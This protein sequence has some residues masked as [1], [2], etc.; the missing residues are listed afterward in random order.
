[1]AQWKGI[2]GTD[3]DTDTVTVMVGALRTAVQSYVQNSGYHVYNANA[4][5][6]SRSLFNSIHVRNCPRCVP[7]LE[8]IFTIHV[9][10]IVWLLGLLRLMELNCIVNIAQY[11][12]HTVLILYVQSQVGNHAEAIDQPCNRLV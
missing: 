2:Y 1:M 4:M 12:T 9:D 6:F 3:T 10:L 8:S 7:L 5:L 11:P